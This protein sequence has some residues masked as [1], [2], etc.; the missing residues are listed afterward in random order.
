MNV[1]G[2]IRGYMSKSCTNEKFI[3][4]VTE[5]I[6]KQLKEWDKNYEVFLM[7][8]SNYEIVVKNNEMYCFVSFSEN[9]IEQLQKRTPFSLDCKI[10]KELKEQGLTIKNGYGNYIDLTLNLMD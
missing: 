2:V 8:F 4:H 1:S 6:E 3:I 5:V 9:E 7:K 10:W